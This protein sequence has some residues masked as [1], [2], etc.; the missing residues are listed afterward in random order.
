M[1]IKPNS[2]LFIILIFLS[3]SCST[4]YMSP[5]L[6]DFSDATDLIGKNII[7]AL[8][9]LQ[10]EEINV[11]IEDLTKLESIKPDDFKTKVLTNEK[12]QVRKEL[13]NYIV[14]Y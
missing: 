14:N 7:Y 2:V 12:L 4:K 5:R 11:L 10:T 8:E 1:K 9:Q 6:E 3:I 13:V